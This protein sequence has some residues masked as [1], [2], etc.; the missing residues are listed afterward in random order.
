VQTIVYILR[1]VFLTTRH[2]SSGRGEK[3]NEKKDEDELPVTAT[4]ETVSK[5]ML[6]HLS[7]FLEKRKASLN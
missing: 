5:A 7:G 1:R 2:F 6:F 3:R 4:K